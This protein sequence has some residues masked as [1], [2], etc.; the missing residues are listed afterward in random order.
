M[1]FF[2]APVHDVQ[3]DDPELLANV[4]IENGL[5]LKV[6][7]VEDPAFT[8]VAVTEYPELILI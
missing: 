5:L 1:K 6:I 3:D 2:F 4:N 7:A 8:T